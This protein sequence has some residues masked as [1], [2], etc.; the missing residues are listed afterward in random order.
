MKLIR[1][2]INQFHEKCDLKKW[3]TTGKS[4]WNCLCLYIRMTERE[5]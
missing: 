1:T 2:A 4:S 5:R 3:K